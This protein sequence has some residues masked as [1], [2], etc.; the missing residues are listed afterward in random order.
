MVQCARCDKKFLRSRGRINEN[1]KFGLNFYCS[2]ACLAASRY[3][4]RMLACE[5]CGKKFE[6][7]LNDVLLHNYCSSSCAATINNRKFPKRG[8][9]FKICRGCSKRFNGGNLYCSHAC[10]KKARER[11]NPQDLI[12]AINSVS[13]K[14]GRVPAKRE[15]LE[16]ASSCTYAFGS[17]NNAIAAAGLQPNRSHDHRMYKRMRTAAVDG[18]LCDSISEA[19][20]DNWLHRNGIKH[21]RDAFYPSGK[22]KTDWVLKN[23]TFVEYFGLAADSPRY[24]RDVKV[25]K[26]ICRKYGI[27]LVA[28]YPEDLYPTLN[29]DKKFNVSNGVLI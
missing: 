18:H 11:H 28:I 24:D 19:I 14:L 13:K 12:A 9:G 5:N 16:L 3:K 15:V 22:Y 7:Y 26:E 6:R 20:I 2:R 4:R 1:K 25:K 29:L 10:V 8:P 21:E 23:G 27:K 17:W